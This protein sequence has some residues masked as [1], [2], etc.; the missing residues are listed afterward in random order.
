MDI[1]EDDVPIQ[2]ASEAKKD[3]GLMTYDKELQETEKTIHS[4]EKELQSREQAM[5][6]RI[7]RFEEQLVE[8]EKEAQ[9]WRRMQEEQLQISKKLGVERDL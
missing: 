4:I 7:P 2:N 3:K 8:A 9:K 6:L 5:H 1:Y